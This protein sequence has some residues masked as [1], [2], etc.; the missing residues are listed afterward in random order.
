MSSDNNHRSEYRLVDSITVFIETSAS[1]NGEPPPVKV[2]ISETVDVS[3]NGLQVKLDYE[4]PAGS[5]LPLCV[6]C[7]KPT[8]TFNLTGE[9][10]WVRQ[11]D[12]A[13]IFLVGFRILENDQT[14]LQGWK[15]QVSQLLSKA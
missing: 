2:T 9:V 14:D 6:Q 7:S 10:M 11:C 1:P 4:L 12:V 8:A 13:G 3:A 15:E 5:L